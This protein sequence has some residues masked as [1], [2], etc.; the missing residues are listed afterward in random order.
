MIKIAFALFPVLWRE[1]ASLIPIFDK[2][3][4][5]P[6]TKEFDPEAAFALFRKYEPMAYEFAKS[7]FSIGKAI[8]MVLAQTFTPHKMTRQ[9]EETWFNRVSG[10]GGF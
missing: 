1:R 7:G 9:E 10:N 6:S 2:W 3:S 4:K 5:L 8:A